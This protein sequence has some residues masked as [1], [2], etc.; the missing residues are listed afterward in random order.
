MKQCCNDECNQGRDCPAQV[1]RI[2][3]SYPKEDDYSDEYD[4]Y[5][6]LIAK[7]ALVFTL[8]VIFGFIGILAFIVN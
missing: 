3:C 4:E 5:L 2:G 8:L 6:Q 7:I 1:A